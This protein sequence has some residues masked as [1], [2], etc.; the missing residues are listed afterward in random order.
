MDQLWQAF[1]WALGFHVKPESLTVVQ[2]AVRSLGVYALGWAVLRLA[3]IRLL[4]RDTAFDVVL[5]F[6][7][8]S[9]LSR[10]INGSAPP[11]TTFIAVVLLV[12]LHQ[13]LAWLSYRSAAASDFLNGHPQPLI[14]SGHILPEQMRKQ[15][16]SPSDLDEELRLRAH[17][18]EPHRIE[19][20]RLERNG[21]ISF[22]KR[23]QV[24]EVEV[25]EGVQTVRIELAG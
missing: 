21:E 22:L 3:R 6:V 11:Q 8:G 12:L 19:E 25:R 16:I 13:F 17:T 14:R 2:I 9:T 23:F 24:V 5:G 18:T 10:G 7:L 4:S 1:D 20:A 15:R